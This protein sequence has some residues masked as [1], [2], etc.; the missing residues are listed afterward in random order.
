MSRTSRL[1]NNDEQMDK[2]FG[3]LFGRNKLIRQTV[4]VKFN[5][6]AGMDS[7]KK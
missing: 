3:S 5:N 1:M 2:M 4:T 6:V 7:A